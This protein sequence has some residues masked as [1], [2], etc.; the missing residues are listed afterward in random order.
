M[1][2]Y[3]KYTGRKSAPRQL[4]EIEP[5]SG[6]VKIIQNGTGGYTPVL[7]G[8]SNDVTMRLDP[9]D[10]NEL[11]FYWDGTELYWSS[12]YSNS[13]SGSGATL[14]TTAS[15]TTGVITDTTIVLNWSAVT[16]ATG[17][18]IER[19]TSSTFASV[20]TVLSNSNV[21][22]LTDTGLTSSTQYYYRVKANASGYI[23]S[24]W[25]VLSANT[26]GWLTWLTLGVDATNGNQQIN[27]N[28]GLCKKTATDSWNG[29]SGAGVAVS[30]EF[31]T[32]GHK[33]IFKINSVSKAG[34]V[35]LGG[36]TG[37]NNQNTSGLSFC[38]Y[39]GYNLTA[40]LSTIKLGVT[41]TTPTQAYSANDWGAIYY[42][43]SSIEYQHSIDGVTF[44]TWKTDA[45]TPS[46]SYNIQ[47]QM[48]SGSTNGVSE[49]KII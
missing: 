31:L 26:I 3:A 34:T 25:I 9:G 1:T 14:A 17:Y 5:A 35:S 23:S 10:K 33:V 13:S 28:K 12:S 45:D 27:S 2:L 38:F 46:G 37:I 21:L 8:V 47:F 19:S 30:N 7:S 11:G 22:T 48:Y 32:S 41:G 44:T 20:T 16:N 6:I 15:F 36:S 24:N 40:F 43:G 49:I 42:N 29:T 18:T 4:E 39:F